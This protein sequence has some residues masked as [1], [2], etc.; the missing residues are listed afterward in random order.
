MVVFLLEN[1]KQVVSQ[2][3]EASFGG[4]DWAI[5]GDLGGKTSILPCIAHVGN[6]VSLY[7]K[8]THP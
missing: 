2:V 1:M 7:I 8:H 5:N 4:P 3:C 6:T